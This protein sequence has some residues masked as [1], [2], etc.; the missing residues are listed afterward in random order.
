MKII[1]TK[2]LQKIVFLNILLFVF[3]SASGQILQRRGSGRA[4]NITRKFDVPMEST[5]ILD[6][7]SGNVQISGWEKTEIVIEMTLTGRSDSI[8]QPE[9]LLSAD[10]L[11]ISGDSEQRKLI[12]GHY[13]IYAPHGISSNIALLSGNISFDN[14]N[15]EIQAKTQAGNISI[16]DCEGPVTVFTGAGQIDANSIQN[17]A[18]FRSGAG[19]V[20]LKELTGGIDL[21]LGGGNIT[22]ENINGEINIKSGGGNIDITNVSGNIKISCGGGSM[23]VKTMRGFLRMATGGGEIH[24]SDIQGSVDVSTGGGDVFTEITS[25]DFLLDHSVNIKARHGNVSIIIP[26][27]MPADVNAVI[28]YRDRFGADYQI[29]S[30]I[31]L[32]QSSLEKGQTK[33][34]M[35]KG[36]LNNGGHSILLNTS[37]GNIFIKK[38]SAAK[39]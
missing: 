20:N 35:A 7:I 27:N 30:D 6:H 18:V 13:I 38:S 28:Y 5:I 12:R 2:I 25:G 10:S 39:E 37:N 4:E 21:S 26:E 16:S 17:E 34:L 11:F 23:N 14:V 19:L 31:E 3:S 33:T 15:G 8:I 22:A 9:I 32:M 1:N 24:L 29:K 36:S